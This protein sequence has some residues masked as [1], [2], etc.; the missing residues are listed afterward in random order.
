[1]ATFISLITETQFGDEHIYDTV[2][3]AERFKERAEKSGV[4]VQ[5]M[6]WTN[7]GYD[8]VL[9]LEAADAKTVA[10]LLYSLTAGGAVRTQTM[11]AFD[12]TEM[13]AILDKS[14][15]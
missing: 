12:A 5:G 4:T 8:G 3:R 7:G 13:R 14:Q 10:S 15:A 11:Q 9:V 2:V 6:Y 1:M